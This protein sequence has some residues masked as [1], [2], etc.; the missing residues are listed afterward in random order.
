MF[1]VYVFT[2]KTKICIG[3]VC[4]TAFTFGL[5]RAQMSLEV[6]FLIFAGSAGPGK[7]ITSG[8]SEEFCPNLSITICSSFA[9]SDLQ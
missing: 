8:F 1:P 3:L 4:S 7:V 9:G 5:H 6:I 2:K